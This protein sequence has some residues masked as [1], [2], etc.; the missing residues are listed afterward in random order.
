MQDTIV[1]RLCHAH[2]NTY[3]NAHYDGD[4]RVRVAWLGLLPF[5]LLTIRLAGTPLT[6]HYA[7]VLH[8]HCV[9]TPEREASFE[10]FAAWFTVLGTTDMRLFSQTTGRRYSTP[11]QVRRFRTPPGEPAPNQ[12]VWV[13]V[14]EHEFATLDAAARVLVDAPVTRPDPGT[15]DA[16]VEPG[17]LGTPLGT[18]YHCLLQGVRV[19]RYY[20]CKDLLGVMA[21]RIER[22]E[23]ATP[24]YLAWRNVRLFALIPWAHKP[25]FYT[26]ARVADAAASALLNSGSV[27]QSVYIESDAPITEVGG[28]NLEATTPLPM[29]EYD[30][31][32]YRCLRLQG[33]GGAPQLLSVDTLDAPRVTCEADLT[34]VVLG[35]G[36]APMQPLG[37]GKMYYSQERLEVWHIAHNA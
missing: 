16:I 5:S 34:A 15:P 25:N 29:F 24:M 8:I 11:L 27:L 36:V 12:E 2:D 18:L 26:L 30:L 7:D 1:H 3:Q 17:N 32:V 9:D 22:H 37:V 23:C 10:A 33:V 6:A 19:P 28:V 4:A 31:G 13:M 20:C 35:A 21:L 14:G